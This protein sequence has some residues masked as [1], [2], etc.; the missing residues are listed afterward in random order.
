[1]K[2]LITLVSVVLLS[3]GFLTTSVVTA[4]PLDG[5]AVPSISIPMTSLNLEKAEASCWGS[6]CDR[7]CTHGGWCKLCFPMLDG[8]YGFYEWSGGNHG[9]LYSPESEH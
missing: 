4:D 5:L 6:V 2:K 8:M 9:H 1:M 7:T 3:V